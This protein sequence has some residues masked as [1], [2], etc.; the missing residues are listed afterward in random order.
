MAALFAAKSEA[1]FSISSITFLSPTAVRMIFP[2][3][4][5]MAASSPALLMTVATK[6]FSA[7]FLREHVQPGDGHD[8]VAVN[9]IAFFGRRAARG[10]RRRRARCRGAPGARRLWRKGFSGNIEP[11][12]SLMFFSVRMISEDN[13]FRAKFAQDAGRGF[14][15][16]PCAQSTTTRSLRASGFWETRLGKFRCSGPA[17]RQCG[18]PC[19]FHRQSGEWFRFAA[20]NESFNFTL[21]PVVELVA[22]GAEKFDAVVG[23]GI[24]RAVMTM[25]ASARKLRVT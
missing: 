1:C 25:P 12:F 16:A 5:L 4:D 10:R 7:K 11:Q 20:E 18:R 21:D 6:V 3:A 13:H 15:A 17:R 8:V 9:Q 23:I 14:V 22:V 24:V 19:R 2:P